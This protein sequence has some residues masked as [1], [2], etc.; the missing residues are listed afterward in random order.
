MDR[1]NHLHDQFLRILAPLVMAPV[2]PQPA[3][4]VRLGGVVRAGAD[5]TRV[6]L[7]AVA[8]EFGLVGADGAEIDVHAAVDWL[9]TLTRADLW[10]RPV[11]GT[12]TAT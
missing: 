8:V 9:R 1:E 5:R 12:A 6:V 7:D 3:D 4:V 11:G 2:G 10:R